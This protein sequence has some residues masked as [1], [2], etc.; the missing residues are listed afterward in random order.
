MTT[1]A[2]VKLLDHNSKEKYMHVRCVIVP[3]ISNS[4]F[5]YYNENSSESVQ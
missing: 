5:G 2:M 4:C 1:G 3:R